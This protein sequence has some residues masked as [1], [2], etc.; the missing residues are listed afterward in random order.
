VIVVGDTSI[1]LNLCCVRQ[2][3]LLPALFD[4]VFAPPEVREE[5]SRACLRLTRFAN[6]SFP[7]WVTVQPTRQSF[8]ARAPWA[9]LDAGESAALELALEIPADA[10]LMDEAD[11]RATAARLG[12]ITVGALGILIRAKETGLLAAVAPVLDAMQREARFFLAP[13]DRQKALVL[14]GEAS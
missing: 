2:E 7:P 1:F 8:S 3:G 4:H 9:R 5:F 14:A 11:G 10:V 13:A 6:L 12:I